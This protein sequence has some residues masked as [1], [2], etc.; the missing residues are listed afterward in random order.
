M[1]GEFLQFLL[2][3]LKKLMTKIYNPSLEAN[4]TLKERSVWLLYLGALFFILYGSANQ[5]A[6]LTSPHESFFMQW[7]ENIPFIEIFIIPYMSSDILFA[8][9]LLLTQTR[10]ELRVLALRIFITMTF[11]VFVFV[12]YPL[13]FSFVKPET[14]NFLF[15]MLELDLA[16]N[17]MP[18]L[19][20]SLAIVL[21]FSMKEHISNIFIKS[22]LAFWFILI[23]L[24]TLFV[25]QHHF[26]DIPT[27]AVVGFTVVY[28]IS[29]KKKTYLTS[30]FMTP[31]SLKMS[32]Y[33]LIG[34]L[35]SIILYFNFNS[36]IFIYLFLTALSISFI[37]A[38]GF[39]LLLTNEKSKPNIFQKI[40]FA[41]Y[42]I[43]SYFSWNYYKNKIDFKSQLNDNIYFGRQATKEEYKELEALG[44]K[45]IINLAN[46]QQFHKTNIK[47]IRY[48]LLD[49]TM[50]DPVILHQIIKTIEKHSNEK[51]YIHCTLGMSR[52]IL[53]I[54]SYLLYKKKSINEVNEIMN[55]LRPIY[56]KS[57]YMSI[58]LELYEKFISKNN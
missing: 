53:A 18:S 41:P 20:I 5:Y 35:I 26:I 32:L 7:E 2:Q 11:S 43:A 40:L 17:Q 48:P 51:I 4:A 10:F 1:T 54:S 36:F 14:S 37:Y 15:S 6:F 47:E 38:F 45:T 44:I 12:L 50:Q 19:H 39:N 46:D 49:M 31:R 25:Y 27:G 29:S 34:V 3:S 8:I 9:A 22:F 42:F 30:R 52:S 57:K 24:S 33:Y 55:K 56:V 16:Y 13:Q 28:L 21:W 58:N 23:C